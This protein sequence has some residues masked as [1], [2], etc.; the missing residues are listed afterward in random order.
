LLRF[1]PISSA[2]PLWRRPEDVLGYTRVGCRG[3]QSAW[4]HPQDLK[5]V[6][7]SIDSPDHDRGSRHHPVGSWSHGAIWPSR[8]GFERL[9][10]IQEEILWL[11]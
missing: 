2:S 10:E 5:A 1:T 7:A 11:Q 8:S 3:K 4:N 9:A 6:P